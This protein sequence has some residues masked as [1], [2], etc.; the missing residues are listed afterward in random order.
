MYINR[1]YAYRQKLNRLWIWSQIEKQH[2]DVN[3]HTS[4]FISSE[5]ECTT[6]SRVVIA[7]NAPKRCV[8]S[9]TSYLLLYRL[10]FRRKISHLFFLFI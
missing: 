5:F 6:I 7:R 3:K 8:F 1:K 4:K 9:F 2:Y 10:F